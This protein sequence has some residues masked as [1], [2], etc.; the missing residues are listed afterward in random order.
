MHQALK[1]KELC[2]N[3]QNFT[4]YRVSHRKVL[5]GCG[6]NIIPPIFKTKMLIY[7]LKASLEV[8]ILFANITHL[9]EPGI[10]KMLE[11][12]L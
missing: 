3:L 8:K 7:E 2:E 9:I 5:N 12:D 6:I 1:K 4:M 11:R 10:R